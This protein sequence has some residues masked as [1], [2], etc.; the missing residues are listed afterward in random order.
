MNDELAQYQRMRDSDPAISIYWI[1]QPINRRPV[2]L[3]GFSCIFCKTTIMDNIAG[4]AQSIINA[5]VSLDDIGI[6]GTIRCKRC[7]QDYRLIISSSFNPN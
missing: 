1:A 7:R 5:P 3:N 2:L 4:T 6:S